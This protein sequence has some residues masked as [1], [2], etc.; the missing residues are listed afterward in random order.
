MSSKPIAL[1]CA[2][3]IQGTGENVSQTAGGDAGLPIDATFCEQF[4]IPTSFIS[5]Q[6]QTFAL[7]VRDW[8]AALQ[9]ELQWQYT[10]ITGK[11]V[12]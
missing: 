11:K 1:R 3:W 5:A 7:K 10:K 12:F 8:L 2:C 9:S 4:S 6:Q